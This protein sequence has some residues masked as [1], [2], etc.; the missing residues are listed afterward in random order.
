[1]E[2]LIA[3]LHEDRAGFVQEFPRQQQPVTEI[4]Q[5]SPDLRPVRSEPM[6]SSD[7]TR[8]GFVG[9]VAFHQRQNIPGAVLT[10]F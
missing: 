3:D 1:V 9:Q 10:K 8:R 5:I 4:T 6:R 2:V 7:G